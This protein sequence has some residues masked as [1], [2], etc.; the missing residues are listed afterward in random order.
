VAGEFSSSRHLTVACGL[1]ALAGGIAFVFGAWLL[2]AADPNG[3]TPAS[4][5]GP[6]WTLRAT[7]SAAAAGC[8]LRFASDAGVVP[9]DV[10]TP[11]FLVTL[12][13]AAADVA[14]RLAFLRYASRLALRVPDA[15]VAARVASMVPA[16]GLSLTAMAAF[17]ALRSVPMLDR[18][19]P[20]AA[21][22]LAVVTLV[23]LRHLRHLRRGLEIQTDYARGIWSRSPAARP[24]AAG[25]AP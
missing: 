3:S 2:S 21:V 13:A 19:A 15:T 8:V 23:L 16:Y 24:S 17:D 5:A 11:V 20:A 10:A 6:R 25:L 12:A 7:L 1:A 4:D 18:L 9:P 14:G 22:A